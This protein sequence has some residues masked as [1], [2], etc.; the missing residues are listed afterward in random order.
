VVAPARFFDPCEIR[1]EVGLRIESGAV[2]A[3]Q[4][5]VVLVTAPVRPREPRELDRLDR[6]RVQQVRPAAEVREVTLCVEGDRAFGCTDEL[7]LVRLPLRLEALARLLG[8]DLL[9]GPVAPLLE[10]APD[11]LLDPR[12]IVLADRLGKLE[13]VVEAVLD[14]RTDRDLHPGVEPADRLGQEMGRRMP[15][16][17]EGVGIVPVAGR[18]DLDR[19][20]V[21]ER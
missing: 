17:I 21:L 1:V 3:R 19:L 9:T 5:R 7:D 11:L 16:Y 14:R 10:L 15:E 20:T 12:Q 8:R 18:E 6:A 2:D 4:L 13:V